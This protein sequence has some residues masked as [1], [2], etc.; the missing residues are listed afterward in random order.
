MS[1]SA[2]VV[3]ELREKTGAGMME[4]KKALVEVDGDI[5]KAVDYLRTKGIAKA[6]KRAGKATAEGIVNSYI[7]PGGGVGVLIEV[8]CETDFVARTD[9]FQAFV[10]DIAMH[11]AATNPAAISADEIDDLVL[12]KEREIYLAQAAEE[13]KPAEIAAKIV[14][15][16]M[17]KYRKEN[18]LLDQPFVRNPDETVG[19][20]LKSK[21]ASLGENIIIKRF[22]RFSISD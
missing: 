15:G 13:G 19:E 17:S 5:D 6:A 21:I 22:A 14:E 11:I 1:I 2:A 12:A 18:A 16:R 9:E 4:C 3:K 8:N 10:R 20:L 7:H